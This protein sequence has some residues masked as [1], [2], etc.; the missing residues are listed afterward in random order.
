MIVDLLR[1]YAGQYHPLV[2]FEP[3]R[4]HCYRFDFTSDNPDLSGELLANTELFSRYIEEKLRQNGCKYGI[5]GY[6]ELRVLYAR[7]R[8]FDAVHGL[9][10]AAGPEP[11]R[12]HLGLDIWGSAGTPIMAPIGGIL[13][14]F[15]FN[16]AFGDYGA[17]IILT[18]NLEG[19]SFHTLYGHLSINSLRNLCAGNRVRQGE[20]IGEMGMRFENG[21]WPPHVHMQIILDMQ[22]W[23]GDYPGVC[24]FSQKVD[25]MNNCPDPDLILHMNRFAIAR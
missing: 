23:E 20:I 8:H 11:R 10:V 7:S 25:W 22:G 1:K 14:S 3:S 9:V 2:P 19:V 5:G 15:A 4:D 13:H 16:D 18:H 6:G 17:T 21:Q 24:P 12:L